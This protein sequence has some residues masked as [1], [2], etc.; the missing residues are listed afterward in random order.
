MRFET[1]GSEYE[2]PY[3]DSNNDIL[4]GLSKKIFTAFIRDENFTAEKVYYTEQR[5]IMSAF[6]EK[7][8]N[9]NLRPVY[10]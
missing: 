9:G 4:E 1:K 6:S 10:S 3:V 5:G 2:N 8:G 7:A